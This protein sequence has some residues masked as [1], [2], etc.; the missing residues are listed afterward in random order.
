MQVG[1]EVEISFQTMNY[2]HH[3]P[4]NAGFVLY[5]F[6]AV[7]LGENPPNNLLHFVHPVRPDLASS[8]EIVEFFQSL[9]V[10]GKHM[11]AEFSAGDDSAGIITT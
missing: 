6:I 11:L 7:L 4:G 8:K 5:R 1:G 2:C 9:G 3:I 10:R